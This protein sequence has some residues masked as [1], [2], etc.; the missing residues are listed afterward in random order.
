MSAVAGFGIR[1]RRQDS[2]ALARHSLAL[3]SPPGRPRLRPQAG[4]AQHPAGPQ[5]HAEGP[6]IE[7]RRTS[8]TGKFTSATGTRRHSAPPRFGRSGKR[9]LT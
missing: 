9:V 4:H 6:R 5:A 2:R 7:W 1:H 3:A 8:A